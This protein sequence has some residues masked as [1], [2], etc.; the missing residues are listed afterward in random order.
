MV[1]YREQ[2]ERL[3]GKSGIIRSRLWELFPSRA[4]RCRPPYMGGPVLLLYVEFMR[5]DLRSI[6]RIGERFSN[7]K[8]RA[9]LV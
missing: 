1:W 4:K 3:V 2:E 7:S 6:R 5:D 8:Y 9:R